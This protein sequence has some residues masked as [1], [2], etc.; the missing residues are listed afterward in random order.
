MAE[1]KLRKLKFTAREIEDRLDQ[2]QKN[3]DKIQ[4]NFD[5]DS[6][7]KDE[8]ADLYLPR[9]EFDD[10]L[11]SRLA[12]IIGN[13]PEALRTLSAIVDELEKKQDVIDIE[14]LLNNKVDKSELDRYLTEHQDLSDYA[15]VNDVRTLSEKIDNILADSDET[16]D[17]FKELVD[18]ISSKGDVAD[19]I[20]KL[21]G[22]ADK[23]QLNEYAKIES[24]P[25]RVSD[26]ENDE[27]YVKMDALNEYARSADIP[28]VPTKLGQ[29]END[30]KYLTDDDLTDYIKDTQL[31]VVATDAKRYTDEAV[32]KLLDGV[33]AN[34]DTLRELADAIKDDSK[35]QAIND[36]L[37]DKVDESALNDYFTKGESD[38]RY[39]TS[40]QDLSDYARISDIPTV[41]TKISDLENDADFL[42]Q[43]QDLSSYATID[44]VNTKISDLVSGADENFDT[45]RELADAIK[46]NDS[47]IDN[48]NTI[49]AYKTNEDDVYDKSTADDKFV[50]RTKYDE[51]Q[52]KYN[53]LFN[54]V[55]SQ[56]TGDM[57]TALNV[58]YVENNLSTTNT[59]VTITEGELGDFTV[60]ETSKIMTVTAPLTDNTTVSLTSNKAFKLNNT[61][62]DP[63]TVTVNVP[64]NVT[65]SN[66]GLYL[67]GEYNTINIVN[68]S[69][70]STTSIPTVTHDVNIENII[71]ENVDEPQTK[72]ASVTATF[73][74]ITNDPSIV[75]TQTVKDLTIMNKNTENVPSLTIHAPNSTVTLSNSWDVVDAIVSD[76]TLIINS[77]AH[78]NKLSSTG[79][80][81]V[82]VPKAEMIS[83]VIAEYTDDTDVDYLKYEITNENANTLALTGEMTL[84][85]DITRSSSV[86][87]GVISNNKIVWKLNDHNLTVTNGKT[88]AVFM[89]GTS[90][91]DIYGPGTITSNEYGVWVSGENSVANIYG[92]DF[93][94]VTHALYCENGTINVYG[95]SFRVTDDEKRY[96]V[97][98]LDASYT[99][100][101]AHINIAGGK[102]YDWNPAE[103]YG[104]P[105]A[106]VSF[107][108]EGYHVVEGDDK[109]GHYYEVVID[110]SSDE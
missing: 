94:S 91:I 59:S 12:Q 64:Y 47:G 31:D 74:G 78:I 89:R 25:T 93:V 1:V 43:H 40:H 32:S 45:L 95:G 50:D 13:A 109:I 57:A 96:V 88:G 92:G 107:V 36:A 73:T 29:L 10:I 6:E 81:V 7:F 86:T 24:L 62:T 8:V 106:P 28:S 39:I 46:N 22:K 42:T 90:E 110:D 60:P 15:K 98:C 51:L 72:S 68:G 97:N 5:A 99:S 87:Q 66:T 102:F 21:D 14:S 17:S 26:L 16:L 104:E 2:V 38:Y 61:S 70:M 33:D 44:Y 63:V 3:F 37:S 79:H 35:F 75:S 54:V 19:I 11:D 100:G 34:F 67:T 56:A 48:I 69:M 4:Q 55:Y 76:D 20:T 108:V 82:K 84:T 83:D 27:D 18:L 65:S 71:P 105:G 30:V 85:E 58:D 41:P 9:E 80:V 103:S 53:T 23:D 52:N 101:K 77:T 49:L